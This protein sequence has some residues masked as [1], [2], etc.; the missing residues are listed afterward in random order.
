MLKGMLRLRQI[1]AMGIMVGALISGG[2]AQGQSQSPEK[3][4]PG[5]G[6]A[7]TYS[8][9]GPEMYKTWC[10][11]CH[12]LDGKGNGPVAGALKRAPTNLTQLSKK[13]AGKFPTDRVREYVDGRGKANLAHGTREMPVWGEALA[14]ID[15]SAVGIS[16][17]V[18]TLTSY[19]ETLQEK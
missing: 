17:R 5:G 11:S 2:R 14:S 16:F 15:A 3:D 8:L 4:N 19:L 7:H 13:N 18:N 12:G 6:I 9:S 1:T 10:A